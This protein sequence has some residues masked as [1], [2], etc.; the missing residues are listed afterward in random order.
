MTHQ[1]NNLSRLINKY[2]NRFGEQDILVLDLKNEMTHLQ[3]R[4]DRLLFSRG[5]AIQLG[6]TDKSKKAID[7]SKD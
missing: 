1:I 2:S 3:L 7:F 5:I 6:Q 4:Q